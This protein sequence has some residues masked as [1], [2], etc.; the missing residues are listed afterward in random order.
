MVLTSFDMISRYDFDTLW[1]K[2]YDFN[3]ILLWVWSGLSYGLGYGLDMVL[4]VILIWFWSGFDLVWERS[5]A[6][7]W[8]F[9]GFPMGWLGKTKT[10]TVPGQ[11]FG[12]FLKGLY[13]FDTILIQWWYD[14]D[15]VLICF[16]DTF[17]NR[18]KTH[19]FDRHQI[20]SLTH[21]KVVTETI[22]KS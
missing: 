6:F 18:S 1:I 17:K 22:S 16:Q 5:A 15:V 3:M 9:S 10:E 8:D 11:A 20:T 21:I 13:G 12:Q 2:G 4:D 19:T 14:F 7:F